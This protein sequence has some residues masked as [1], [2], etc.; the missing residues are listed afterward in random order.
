MS[1]LDD[2]CREAKH[3]GVVI[4]TDG[5][6]DDMCAIEELSKHYDKATIVLVNAE[7]LPI[8]DYAPANYNTS[9]FEEDCGSWFEQCEVKLAEQCGESFKVP[10]VVDVFLLCNAKTFM[11]NINNLRIKRLCAMIGSSHE[12]DGNDTEWNA[13]Q[14]IE[15][16]KQLQEEINKRRGWRQVTAIECEEFVRPATFSPEGLKYY[17]EYM[18]RMKALNENDCCYDLQCVYKAFTTSVKIIGR[19]YHEVSEDDD[20]DE[21]GI[22]FTK[23]SD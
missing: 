15:S 22:S 6:L 17:A 19:V 10:G 2:V 14:S 11:S 5:L 18:E 23:V 13:S 20:D 12:F 21:I 8:C 16:Y 7:N 3:R 1:V 4:Y 9:R